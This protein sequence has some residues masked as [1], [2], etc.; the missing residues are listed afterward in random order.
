MAAE[1]L[2]VAQTVLTI[3]GSVDLVM[4]LFQTAPGDPEGKIKDAKLNLQAIQNQVDGLNV[5]N[6]HVRQWLPHLQQEVQQVKRR[7]D[8]YNRAVESIEFHERAV[9]LN[10][11]YGTDPYDPGIG[12]GWG[13]FKL[14]KDAASAAEEAKKASDKAYS[15]WEKITRL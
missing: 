6:K 7:M 10:A 1:A 5:N 2:A 13:F 11:K 9:E 12:I 8:E 3:K 14:S 15:T 4:G